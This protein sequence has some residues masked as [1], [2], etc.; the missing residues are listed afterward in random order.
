VQV[1][2]AE[3]HRALLAR[4]SNTRITARWIVLRA[5]AASTLSS[6]EA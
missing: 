5:W 1:V 2:D 6:G 3:H 4:A